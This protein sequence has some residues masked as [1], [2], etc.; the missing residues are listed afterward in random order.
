[1]STKGCIECEV[2][3]D[4]EVF[5]KGHNQCKNCERLYCQTRVNTFPK[6]FFE[7]LLNHAKYHASTRKA[8]GRE[9]AGDFSLTFQEIE[10]MHAAQNGKCF[11]SSIPYNLRSHTDWMCSLERLDNDLGYTIENYVLVCAEFNGAATWSTLKFATFIKHLGTIHPPNVVDFAQPLKTRK[12]HVKVVKYVK[13][14][15]E[16][17]RCTQCMVEKPRAMFNK[18][19]CEGCKECK[20]KADCNRREHGYGFMKLFVSRL[21]LNTKLRNV[22]GRNLEDSEMTFEY[23]VDLFKSQHGLCSYSGIPMN[24][25]SHKDIDWL[26]SLERMNTSKGYIRGNVCFIC[27]EFNTPDHTLRATGHTEVVGNSG[28][29]KEKI[30]YLKL[31]I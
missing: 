2:E 29:S 14:G 25:G 10:N 4:V 27:F 30:E 21:K 28:W 15:I 7:Q 19:L 23:L 17:V 3:Q 24:F 16:F 5:R 22:K 20:R 31:F 1:M 13:D 8:S 12:P 18:F 9:R 26:C 11:Y 6:V